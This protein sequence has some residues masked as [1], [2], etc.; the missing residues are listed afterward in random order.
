MRLSRDFI[1]FFNNWVAI[2]IFSLASFLNSWKHHWSDKFSLLLQDPYTVP[3]II[4]LFACCCTACWM[5]YCCKGIKINPQKKMEK[6]QLSLGI[7]ITAAHIDEC[8]KPYKRTKQNKI[9]SIFH[10]QQPEM[11]VCLAS[12]MVVA[13]LSQV[14]A[15]PLTADCTKQR[16][17]FKRTRVS[18]K[19]CH[20]RLGTSQHPEQ[21]K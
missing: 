15:V 6:G 21:V 3:D 16:E 20:Q 12:E 8:L 18:W 7:V 10:G 11:N 4:T 1:T 2:A 9:I 5:H 13:C 14:P 17:Q 19:H